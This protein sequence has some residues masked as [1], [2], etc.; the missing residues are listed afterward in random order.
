MVSGQNLHSTLWSICF[1]VV[2]CI[3]GFLLCYCTCC[4]LRKDSKMFALLRERFQSSPNIILSFWVNSRKRREIA[5]L[6]VLLFPPLF[7]LLCLFLPFCFS[8]CVFT[9]QTLKRFSKEVDPF[10][11][12]MGYLWCMYV[13]RAYRRNLTRWCFRPYWL[14]GSVIIRITERG[15]TL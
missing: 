11:T 10:I 4:L 2:Y 13:T 12:Q 9:W 8:F 7:L 15:F 14:P 1:S 6:L 5:F 3:C